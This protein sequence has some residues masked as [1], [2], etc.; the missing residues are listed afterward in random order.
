MTKEHLKKLLPVMEG[1]THGEIIQFKTKDS[2]IWQDSHNPTWDESFEY[3]IKPLDGWV[4]IHRIDR[5]DYC[6]DILLYRNNI[7]N[8]DESI[9]KITQRYIREYNCECELI[10]KIPIPIKE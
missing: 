9:N 7:K 5:C 1:M 6:C 10:N 4:L 2:N 3:R 8:L